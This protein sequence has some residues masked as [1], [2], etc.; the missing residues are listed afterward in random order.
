[1]QKCGFECE[2]LI[3]VAVKCTVFWDIKPYYA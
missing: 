2:A 3:A 1:M